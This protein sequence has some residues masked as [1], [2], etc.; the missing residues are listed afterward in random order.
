MRTRSKRTSLKMVEL[1]EKQPILLKSTFSLPR[2]I[3]KTL[4]EKIKNLVEYSYI[5]EDA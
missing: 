4:S 3:S 2:N 1:S 5:Q